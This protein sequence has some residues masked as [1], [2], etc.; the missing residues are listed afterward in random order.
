MESLR[1]YVKIAEAAEMLGVFPDHAP[2]MGRPGQD[3]CSHQSGLNRYR[4]FRRSDLELFLRG[5]EQSAATGSFARERN[6]SDQ[7]EDSTKRQ[8]PR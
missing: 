4:L 1:D 3:R 6:Q 7:A 2:K 8:K 5:I